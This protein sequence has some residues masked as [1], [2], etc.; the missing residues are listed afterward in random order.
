MEPEGHAPRGVHVCAALDEQTNN[1]VVST[2]ARDMEGEDAIDDRVHGLT[3][4][5]GV[6]DKAEVSRRRC[7]VEAKM[8]DYN[9]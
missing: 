2:R 3:V 1:Q 8:W 6:G 7:R 9:R 5:Q 4:I